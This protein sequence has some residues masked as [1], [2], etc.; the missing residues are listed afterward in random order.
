MKERRNKW[1]RRLR[2]HDE[3]HQPGT[4]SEKETFNEP[5]L[6]PPSYPERQ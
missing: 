4:E 1:V 2:Q 6:N 3:E 5:H